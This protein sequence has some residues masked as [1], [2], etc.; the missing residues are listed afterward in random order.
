[1]IGHL[2]IGIRYWVLVIG[3]WVFGIRPL[4]LFFRQKVENNLRCQ[5]SV[6]RFQQLEFQITKHKY[7]MVRPTVR[8]AHGP[9]QRRRT[10]HFTTLSLVE[11]Q[12][13]MTNP[14]AAD[15]TTGF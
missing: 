4:V 15:Q 7:Q 5:V 6:F 14:T 2:A 10:H 13:T 12:I 9:E 8:Q 3:Y 11:G 1:M